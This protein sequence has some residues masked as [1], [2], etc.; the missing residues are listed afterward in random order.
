MPKITVSFRTCS[1]ESKNKLFD[2]HSSTHSNIM[3]T[4]TDNLKRKKTVK[5]GCCF[6]QQIADNQGGHQC[7]SSIHRGVR[8]PLFSWFSH[9]GKFSGAK[10]SAISFIFSL[11]LAFYPDFTLF[12]IDF[13]LWPLTPLHSS[14][15][16]RIRIYSF[17]K[18][19]IRSFF[20][21]TI[22]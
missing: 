2:I 17:K 15:Y 18:K 22:I 8:D 5:Y 16:W 3:T 20:K 1:I 4:G 14:S 21:F 12:F 19:I 10:I 6:L 11:F 7:Y 9:F 13:C